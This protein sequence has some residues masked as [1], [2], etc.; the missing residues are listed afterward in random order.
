MAFTRQENLF[1]LWKIFLAFISI[2]VFGFETHW[3]LA[4]RT[5]LVF[6]PQNLLSPLSSRSSS[7]TGP[8]SHGPLV[9]HVLVFKFLQSSLCSPKSSSRTSQV[10]S[11]HSF[12]LT[13]PQT[14]GLQSSRFT[15]STFK[16]PSLRI[17]LRINLQFSESSDQSSSLVKSPFGSAVLQYRG[18]LVSWALSSKFGLQTRSLS[19]FGFF[20]NL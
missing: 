7:L 15:K 4:S 5:S 11:L 2:L 20:Q 9:F 6:G 17:C 12:G 13:V 3:S 10:F 8:Q 1:S 14:A 16:S 18:P 19:V